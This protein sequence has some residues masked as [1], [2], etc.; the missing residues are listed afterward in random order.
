M[1]KKS[2]FKEQKKKV[3]ELIRTPLLE[4]VLIHLPHLQPNQRQQDDMWEV[5]AIKLNNTDFE[6]RDAELVEVPTF[7][8]FSVKKAYEE[9]MASF[10]NS[11]R[12]VNKD[13]ALHSPGMT[14][15]LQNPHIPV[16][17]LYTQ[18]HN[19]ILCELFFLSHYDVEVM[20]NLAKERVEAQHKAAFEKHF[21]GD[22][23]SGAPVALD[24]LVA[25]SE[26]D[27]IQRLESRLEEKSK[28]IEFLENEIRRLLDLNHE[29]VANQSG[30]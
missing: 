9:L 16:R 8:G 26:K 14:L 22:D 23:E 20:A 28:R 3:D 15:N 11:V 13:V 19:R 29:L 21:G 7:N 2:Y 5:V 27:K 1:L 10:K 17:E 25:S 30:H 12:D 4:L 24:R 6:E 18:R